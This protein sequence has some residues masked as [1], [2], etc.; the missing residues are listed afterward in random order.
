MVCCYYI[1]FI[2]LQ[3]YCT[4]TSCLETGMCAVRGCFSPLSIMPFPSPCHGPLIESERGFPPVSVA[5]SWCLAGGRKEGRS[6]SASFFL[7]VCL[8]LF[9]PIV[10]AGEYVLSLSPP[11][12][13]GGQVLKLL[14]L[15]NSRR[16]GGFV[17]SLS[18]FLHQVKGRIK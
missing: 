17:L 18:F 5:K 14:N 2:L 9:A 1:H 15:Y 7:L 11:V 6:L 12:Y 8:V 4:R 3:V 16:K 10:S 13:S